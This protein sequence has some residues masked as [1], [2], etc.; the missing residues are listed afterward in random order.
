[1]NDY[2]RL[3]KQ[4]DLATTKIIEVQRLILSSDEQ[5]RLQY[6]ELTAS[7]LSLVR[8]VLESVKGML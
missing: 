6:G 5:L 8:A 7:E 1:M 3:L 4:Q 2:E